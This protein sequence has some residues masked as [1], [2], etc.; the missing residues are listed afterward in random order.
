MTQTSAQNGEV[1]NY[2]THL[3]LLLNGVERRDALDDPRRLCDFLANLVDRIGM[4]ILDGPRS[5]TENADPE[6]Y[7]HSAV[8]IL[9]ESHAAVHTYPMRGSLFL[10]VFSCKP[11]D[12]GKVAGVCREVFGAFD[13]AE[14]LV[15]NRGVHWN[16]TADESVQTW[17]TTRGK[18]I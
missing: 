8:I 13:I 9:Y 12:E 14:R 2:G 16:G 11:F 17:V 18:G 7:G 4:R 5:A 10:D 15:L 6:K 3:L 1:L